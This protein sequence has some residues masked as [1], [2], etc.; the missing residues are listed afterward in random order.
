MTG[1]CEDR[2]GR[3]RKSSILHLASLQ[4]RGHLPASDLVPASAQGNSDLP[5]HG[6]SLLVFGMVIW[7]AVALRNRFASIAGILQ[8]ANPAAA[9]FGTHS[10]G[11]WGLLVA[12]HY[13]GAP[14]PMPVW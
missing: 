12:A 8:G 2:A 3:N 10:A 1:A 9:I 14:Q 13:R 11:S 5:H 4:C 7:T 6:G